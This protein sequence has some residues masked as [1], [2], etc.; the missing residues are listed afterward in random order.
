MHCQAFCYRNTTRSPLLVRPDA[1]E[2]RRHNSP[3]EYLRVL[4]GP[5]VAAT[6]PGLEDCRRDLAFVS[7][8]IFSTVAHAIRTGTGL[9]VVY[10][11]MSSPEGRQRTIYPHALVRAPG[12]WHVRAWCAARKDFRDF[13]LG[14][15]KSVEPSAQPAP[16]SRG[17]DSAWNEQVSV[18]I[19]AHPLLS[20]SQQQMIAAEY[21]PGAAARKLTMRRCLIGYVVQDLRIATSPDQEKPPA[22]QLCVQKPNSILPMFPQDS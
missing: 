22:F 12:R 17:E 18:D 7:P 3:D 13:N 4:S 10:R 15:M 14:R 5:P 9:E 2:V 19:V 1:A 16:A 21:F 6:A 11:S 20:P 8:Q